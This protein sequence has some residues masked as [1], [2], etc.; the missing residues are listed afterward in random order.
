VLIGAL[1]EPRVASTASK[2]KSVRDFFDVEICTC[3]Y[4]FLV[5]PTLWLWLWA[6]MQRRKKRQKTIRKIKARLAASSVLQGD[7]KQMVDRVDMK[8]REGAYG[9][10][11][12]HKSRRN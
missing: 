2:R 10:G 8:R 5:S 3:H 4:N 11:E 12:R 1:H 9:D 7:A 6:W